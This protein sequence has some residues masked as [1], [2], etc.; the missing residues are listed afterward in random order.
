MDRY[1][2]A[3]RRNS[4]AGRQLPLFRELVGS[5]DRAYTAI[6]GN[7]PTRVSPIFGQFILICHKHLL[8]AAALITQAQPDDGTA[9]TRRAIEVARTALAI[10][11]DAANAELWIAFQQRHERWVKRQQSEK[12]KTFH[13]R[14]EAIK[15][16]PLM[17]E[18]DHMLGILSDSAVHFTPEYSASLDWEERIVG[19]GNAEIILNY[20]HRDVREVERGLIFLGAAHLKIL[21]VFDRCLDGWLRSTPSVWEALS[22]LI[23]TG[24]R[25]NSEYEK[26]YGIDR[27]PPI[28]PGS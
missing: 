19:S 25:L 15:G 4:D 5:A 18:L 20:F 11:L 21:E 13:V 16:E 10:K 7:H 23:S 3:Q 26:T 27:T 9:I 2:E 17:D 22:A 24:R 1:F 6:I 8:S 14:F 28:G 12:P